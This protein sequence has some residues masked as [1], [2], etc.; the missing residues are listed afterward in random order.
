MLMMHLAL[1]AT[2]AGRFFGLDGLLRPQWLASPGRV[3]R[4]LVRAS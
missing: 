4:L 2:A 1:F 3:A